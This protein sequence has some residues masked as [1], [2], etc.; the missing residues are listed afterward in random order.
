MIRKCRRVD[1]ALLELAKSSRV[2]FMQSLGGRRWSGQTRN[3]L[4]FLMSHSQVVRAKVALQLRTAR[5]VFPREERGLWPTEPDGLLF[6]GTVVAEA[7][8]ETTHTRP[9]CARTRLLSLASREFAAEY[10]PSYSRA[11]PEKVGALVAFCR[12]KR[13][14][15]S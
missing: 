3:L 4:R 1:D 11:C 13:F 15:R 12:R 2:D 5:F 7:A 6:V 9:L 8:P 10:Y 14:F